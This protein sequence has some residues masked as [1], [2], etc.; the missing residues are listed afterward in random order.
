GSLDADNG[1]GQAAS[2]ANSRNADQ[3]SPPAGGATIENPNPDAQPDEKKG[4]WVIAPIP[5]NSPAIGAGLQWAVIRVFPLNKQDEISPPSSVGIGGVFT[6]NGSR[7]VALGGKLY[8]KEDKYR[9]TTAAGN[10]DINLDVYGVGKAAGDN[11]V[12]V[13]LKTGGNGFF[14]EF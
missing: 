10:A 11:D 13:P 1:M 3:K 7:A 12:Y 4:E 8:L 14:G 2:P 5:I 9:L 6:N